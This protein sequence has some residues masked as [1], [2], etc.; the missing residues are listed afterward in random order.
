M[1]E[2]H[3]QKVFVGMVIINV[4]N[5]SLDIDQLIEEISSLLRSLFFFHPARHRKNSIEI[6]L[7]L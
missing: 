5:I 7:L 3:Q 6:E 4:L 1:V 2:Y